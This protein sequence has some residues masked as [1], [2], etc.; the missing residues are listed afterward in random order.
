[1]PDS[2][3][4]GV[5]TA[6]QPQF[7]ALQKLDSSLQINAMTAGQ[8][9]IR[10]GKGEALSQGTIDVATPLETITFYIVLANTPFLFCL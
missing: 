7:T 9:N 6:G 2:G 5:S 8:H 3:A 10:F 4:A 1:M